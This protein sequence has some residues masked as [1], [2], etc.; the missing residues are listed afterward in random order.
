MGLMVDCP[1]L[2]ATGGSTGLLVVL[3][4]VALG[5][6]VAFLLILRRRGVSGRAAAVI[7]LAIGATTFAVG[8]RT[9]DA[10]SCPPSSNVAPATAVPTQTT[11]TAPAT[12]PT[13]T[14]IPAATTTTAPTTTTTTAPTTTTTVPT[15]TTTTTTIP[16]VPDL[17]PNLT[18]PF[19]PLA[20]VQ[21]TYTV[22]ITNAG[23]A[24][25]SGPMTFVI[26]V[27]VDTTAGEL[28]ISPLASSDW[29][30]VSST[31]AGLTYVS[32]PGVVIAP[33]AVSTLTVLIT[34]PTSLGPGSLTLATTL[35]TGIGGETNAANNSASL[36]A[37][38]TLP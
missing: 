33:G 3:A 12:I 28:T 6:G 24:T 15:T 29:A 32:N 5:A 37:V 38:V 1:Q 14:T 7:A 26:V 23:T 19:T 11:I 36:T 4:A 20:G 22:T 34:W 30:F 21:E 27:D 17:T 9:A 13:T 2:P 31:P 18:G 16:V 25:T 10:Q 35:P 8:D